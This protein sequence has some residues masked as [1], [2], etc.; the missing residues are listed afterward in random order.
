VKLVE[1]WYYEYDENGKKKLMNC[2]ISGNIFINEPARYGRKHELFP[3]IFTYYNRDRSYTPYGLVKDLVDPQDII[4]KSFS[5]SMHIL[6]T[7]QILAERGALPNAALVAQQINKPDA[8][9]ND[10]EDGALSNGRVIIEDHR[11]KAGMAFQ[12][13]EIGVTTMNRISGVNPEL[14]GLHTNARSGTAISMRLRQ[15]NT[16]LTSLYDC[17]QKT[18]KTG[19]QLFAYLTA[20]YTTTKKILRYKLPNGDFKNIE[21]NGKV[22]EVL[23]GQ[24]RTIKQNKVKD[25]F[26]Y[27]VIVTQTDQAANGTEAEFTQ[28]VELAKSSPILAQNPIFLGELIK[29][30]HL[31]NK[32]E[33]ARSLSQPAGTGDATAT[34]GLS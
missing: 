34:P 13:F 30:T 3:F 21:V 20:Q 29:S 22:D 31:N 11:E 12:H 2:I 33:L 17:L 8:I 4:N 24:L 7:R 16:V 10:F 26:K 28:L 14:Q 23:E 9:I 18:K 32:E 15:G 6:G 1:C 25:I 19:A 27:D 5:K